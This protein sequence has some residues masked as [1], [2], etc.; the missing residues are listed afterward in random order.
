MD[1]RAIGLTGILLVCTAL[2]SGC[3]DRVEIDQRGFVIGV[4]IDAPVQSEQEHDGN[5]RDKY[6]I[7]FQIVIPSA[8][9]GG[10]GKS[11]GEGGGQGKAYNN[12]TVQEQT[13]SALAAKLANRTSRLPF[14][15]HL[16]TIVVS[17]EMARSPEG[18]GSIFDF[19]LRDNDMRR[20]AHVIIARD[21]AR[22][23]L[24][25]EVPNEPL[26][27]IYLNIFDRN[28]RS[29][30]FIPPQVRISDVQEKLLQYETFVL[31]EVSFKGK[32]EASFESMAIID[33]RSNRMVG[34]MKGQDT[35][36]LNFMT[37]K[38]KGGVVNFKLEGRDSAF[39]LEK[40]SS[41]IVL[42]NRDPES[43]AFTIR[44]SVD[45]SF[46]ETTALDN[47]SEQEVLD[48]IEKAVSLTIASD[49]EDTLEKLQRKFK[50]D[51][52]GIGSYLYRNHY[53]LWKKVQSNWERGDKLFSQA[54]I[55][56]EVRTKVRRVG[57]IQQVRKG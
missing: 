7:T 34:S 1:R 31:P 25:L 12:I 57:N 20:S 54:T 11:G 9:R 28:R 49:C 13:F 43:L 56:L 29:S 30:S 48:R 19:F 14:M 52:I 44:I 38:V 3:W 24:E 26:P 42:T 23:A 5:A 21:E 16:K 50:K 17:S 53:R 46:N 10:Q 47:F 40:A 4:A 36:S 22:K 6:R 33:G 32:E 2:L 51:V 39:Q 37:G 45:G 55:N 18:L 35:Q 27:A 41:K 8:I 15:E